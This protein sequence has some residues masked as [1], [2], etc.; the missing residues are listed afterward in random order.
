MRRPSRRYVSIP[1]NTG[2]VTDN[3]FVELGGIVV[4]VSIPLNTGLVTDMSAKKIV[5]AVLRVSIPLNTGLV[6]DEKHMSLNV[7]CLSQS[8]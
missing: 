5:D 1:L 8:L 4:T 2:L 3:D 7:W 6:T